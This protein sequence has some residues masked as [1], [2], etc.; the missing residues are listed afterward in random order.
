MGVYQGAY[1]HLK[2]RNVFQMFK[3]Q[4]QQQ[5][6]FTVHPYVQVLKYLTFV[7]PHIDFDH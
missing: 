1:V 6:D 5:H 7:F 4:Q 2:W 3:Q